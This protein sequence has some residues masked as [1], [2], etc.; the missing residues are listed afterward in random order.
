M[1]LTR[2]RV[3]T[4]AVVTCSMF[5]GGSALRAQAPVLPPPPSPDGALSDDDAEILTRGPVHEAFAEQYNPNPE[6][7]LIVSKEPPEP[8]NELPP[9]TRPDGDNVIWVPSYWAWDDEREDFILISG[10]WRNV[11]MGQRWVP[12]SWVPAEGGWMWVKG[13]WTGEE[14][15][16]LTYLPQ[17]PQSLEQGPST[18]APSDNHFWIPG[19]YVYTNNAYAWRGGYWAVGYDEWV[20]VPDRY[21]WTPFGFVFCPGYWDHRLP[22]RGILFAPVYF[23]RPV[24]HLHAGFCYTPYHVIDTGPLAMHLFVR[25]RYCHYYFGDFYDDVYYTRWGITPWAT[26]HVHHHHCDPLLTFYVGYHRRHHHID[27]VARLDS[28]HVYYH[29]HHDHRPPRTYVALVEYERNHKNDKLISQV[30]LSRPLKEHVAKIETEKNVKFRRLSQN[31][32][33]DEEKFSKAV[34][35]ISRQRS[36]VDGVVAGDFGNRRGGKGDKSDDNTGGVNL[37]NN[38]PRQGKLK[39]PKVETKKKTEISVGGQG[40]RTPRTPKL[41]PPSAD[42]GAA[43]TGG[44]AGPSSGK[45]GDQDP[46]ARN[47]DRGTSSDRTRLPGVGPL[48]PGGAPGVTSKDRDKDKDKDQG[49]GRTTL[50]P[51]TGTGQP[52]SSLNPQPRVGTLPQPGG[53]GQGSSSSGNSNRDSKKGNDKGDKGDKGKGS[54]P[55]PRNLNNGGSGGGSSLQGSSGGNPPRIGGGSNPGMNRGGNNNSGGAQSGGSSSSSS[56]GKDKSKDKD[57]EESKKKSGKN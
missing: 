19:T 53:S 22:D 33:E 2:V 21:V 48:D 55:T 30:A 26:Y 24:W 28:W 35:D 9:D 4:A 52:G 49:K 43:G 16:E 3:L 34:R 44:L 18:P 37:A 12:G 45:K 14:N 57:K 42:G 15:E 38:T 1:S 50:Q 39:L 7:G 20:W 8:I 54:S 29:D 47:L 10:F 17:P 40:N 56:K 23:R 51:R 5:F 41:D 46:K 32:R 11:P 6:P 13:F 25:P 31:E 36:Q 27:Y